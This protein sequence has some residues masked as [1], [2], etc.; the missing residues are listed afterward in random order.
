MFETRRLILGIGAMRSGE[1]SNNRELGDG[2][3]AAQG[4]QNATAWFIG[5]WL[6]RVQ[7]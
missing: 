1:Y 5:Y 3:G 6:K 7:S 2:E 4:A